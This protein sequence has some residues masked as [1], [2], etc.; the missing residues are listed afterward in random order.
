MSRL[1]SLRER[2]SETELDGLLVAASANLRYLCGFTGSSGL[3][4]VRTD[5]PVTL[6]TDSRYAGVAEEQLPSEVGVRIATNGIASELT[7]VLASG[8]SGIRFGFEPG[9]ITVADRQEIEERCGEVQWEPAPPLIEEMRACKAPLEVDRIREAVA[10]ADVALGRTLERLQRGMTERALAARLEYELRMAG[11]GRLPFDV[12]ASS[13]SR[14]AL[15]HAEPGDRRLRDGDLLL[16][17]F[18]AT[19][20]GYCCDMT[21]SF[22]LGPAAEW[23]REIHDAVRAAQEVA[24]EAIGVGIPAAEVDRAARELLDARGLA[25]RFG[26]STGHGIGLEVHERPWLSRSSTESLASGQVVTVEPGVYLPG[27]GGVRIED[28]VYV[29]EEGPVTLTV[30]SKDLVEL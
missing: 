16:I 25:E 14:S 3:L 21:R 11:S 7:A 30:V 24:I 1:A 19:S 18:G 6:L 4:V 9:R 13:G 20:E 28:D 8:S 2:L 5:G 10:I 22:V 26:H 17:D 23:Q 15:P 29:T 27:R 12:I